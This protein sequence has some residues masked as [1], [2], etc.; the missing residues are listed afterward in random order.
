MIKSE[1]IAKLAAENPHLT[2]RDIERVVSVVL[3]RMIQALEQGYDLSE[4]YRGLADFLRSLLIAR[5]DGGFSNAPQ[6]APQERGALAAEDEHRG[7]L[8]FQEL[9]QFAEEALAAQVPFPKRLG[10]A[11]EYGRLAVFIVE[12]T[13]LNAES[14]RLDGGIRMAP[15]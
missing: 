3:E 1:L 6:S 13:Y 8:F 12:N 14:I 7:L 4:F 2:Q 9:Q 11:E 10:E 15:R 5:L